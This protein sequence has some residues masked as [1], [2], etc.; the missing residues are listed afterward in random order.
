V[1]YFLL[2][3][4]IGSL[5][6]SVLSILAARQYLSVKP[7]A[8]VDTSPISIL[9]PLSGLDEGL[10]S[11]LRTF[12]A[13][14]YPDFEILFAVRD[15]SDPAVT[16]VNKLL[17]EH[18]RVRA[19]LLLTG[20]PPYANAKVFSLSQMI[21]AA[22]NDL[23]VMS[24][25]DT[26]VTPDFLRSVAAEFQDKT[27]G[28]ATCPYRAVPGNSIWSE[29]ESISLN[30]DFMAGILVARMLE[31]MRFAVGP[32]IVTRRRVIEMLG[33]FDR[34]KNYLAEDFVLGQLAAEA[35]QGVILSSC[36]I[37]HHIGTSNLRQNLAHRLRWVRSTRRSRPAG[38]LGQLFTMPLPLVL[39]LL[40]TGR[41]WWP[42][43]VLALVARVASAYAVSDRVLRA[44]IHWLLL[45]TEDLL[46][47]GIWVLGFFGNTIVW[48]GSKYRLK[49]DGR[50]EAVS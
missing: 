36:V 38:Y 46:G 14:D 15:A 7:P 23:L 6:F 48:R 5:T 13:Q 33:G 18:P 49:R 30:T 20:E 41:Y 34:L 16:V 27:V 8:L 37:E 24:D 22:A 3:L 28:V 25:S 19:R 32:T 11:N 21:R 43:L 4:V 40:S 42:A 47:F 35:G 29:L 2:A 12:F 10:E 39:L 17:Q 9:K 50:F 45:P 1:S 44:R 26:R 31:G